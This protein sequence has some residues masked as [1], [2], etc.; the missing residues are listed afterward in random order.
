MADTGVDEEV[1]RTRAAEIID[2]VHPD[3]EKG[4]IFLKDFIRSHMAFML[5]TRAE[6]VIR[7]TFAGEPW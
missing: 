1:A 6:E 2:H 4:K 5:D 7:A 3:N